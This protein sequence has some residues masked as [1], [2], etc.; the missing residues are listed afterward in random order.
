[1]LAT[2][3][4]SSGGRSSLGEVVPVDLFTSREKERAH[5]HLGNEKNLKRPLE[6]RDTDWNTVTTGRAP[7]RRSRPELEKKEKLRRLSRLEGE[8]G[9]ALSS[10]GC[11]KRCGVL[12]LA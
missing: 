8:L 7:R 9:G 11:G 3:A 1:M 6:R 4:V 5:E 10:Q 12:N 2:E